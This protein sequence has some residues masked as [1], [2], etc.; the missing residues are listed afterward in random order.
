MGRLTKDDGTSRDGVAEYVAVAASPSSMRDISTG[1]ELRNWL[2][3]L[4]RT[5]RQEQTA[6]TATSSQVDSQA[7]RGHI[8][9]TPIESE[10]ERADSGS[11][12]P[13][14]R[15][16]PGGTG[17]GIGRVGSGAPIH[18]SGPSRSSSEIDSQVSHGHVSNTSTEDEG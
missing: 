16:V 3:P 14:A 18:R 9:N 17:R 13:S 8:S 11:L 1:E 7:S 6:A 5:V 10:D 15:R 4:K 2:R 12:G